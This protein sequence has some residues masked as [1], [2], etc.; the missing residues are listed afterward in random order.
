ML[1]TFQFFVAN[2]PV[3][4]GNCSFAPGSMWTAKFFNQTENR[5]SYASMCFDNSGALTG[6]TGTMDGNQ[7]VYQSFAAVNP[8]PSLFTLPAGC[9]CPPHSPPS[10]ADKALPSRIFKGLLGSH[11]VK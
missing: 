3:A 10:K 2:S 8:D 4:A 1:S 5:T 9:T 6:S 7:Y 11:I